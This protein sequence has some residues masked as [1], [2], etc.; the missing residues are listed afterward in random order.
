MFKDTSTEED[1]FIAQVIKGRMEELI[2]QNIFKAENSLFIDNA[3]L[4]NQYELINKG[5]TKGIIQKLRAIKQQIESQFKLEIISEAK[6]KTNNCIAFF[7]NEED[8]NRKGT[9]FIYKEKNRKRRQIMK[10][11]NTEQI[12]KELSVFIKDLY[13]DY[14]TLKENEDLKPSE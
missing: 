5:N 1:Y 4:K 14:S 7:G 11:Q 2:E 3:E 6:N 12:F 10:K 8:R 9:I 13:L